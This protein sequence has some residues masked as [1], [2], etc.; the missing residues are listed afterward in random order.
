MKGE[1][2]V[3][4]NPNVH[5]GSSENNS[6]NCLLMPEEHLRVFFNL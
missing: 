6:K 1:E 4:C 5:H 2:Q 3:M